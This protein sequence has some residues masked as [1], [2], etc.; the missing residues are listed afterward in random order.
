MKKFLLAVL[1]LSLVSCKKEEKTTENSG[2]LMDKIDA[3]KNSG[4]IMGSVNDFQKNLENLKKLTPLTNDELKAAI[5]ETL[6]GLPR[7]EITVGNMSAMSVSSAEAKYHNGESKSI[8]INIMDGAGEGGSSVISILALSL[9]ADMEKT[10]EDGFEK[11]T[12]I[13]NDKAMVTQRNNNGLTSSD[14]K[15]VVKGRYMVDISGEGYT[16]EELSKALAD[17]KI[18]SLP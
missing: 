4:K 16:V 9:N 18:N 11:T 15:T 14:I 3:V 12:K 2:G 8:N 17:L 10:T 5:P 1:V 7:K 6:L 13:G